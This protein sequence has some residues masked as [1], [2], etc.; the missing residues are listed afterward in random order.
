MAG[1]G[2]TA[3]GTRFEAGRV[4][5][6][7]SSLHVM[8]FG[9]PTPGGTAE[10][11]AHGDLPDGS[12]LEVWLVD[13]M[14]NRLVVS[15]CGL[16]GQ[17]VPWSRIGACG[18]SPQTRWCFPCAAARKPVVG[19]VAVASGRAGGR[20]GPP[21]GGPGGGQDGARRGRQ[22]RR[23]WWSARRASEARGGLRQKNQRS[24]SGEKKS[25]RRRSLQAVLINEWTTG[26]R[27]RLGPKLLGRYEVQVIQVAVPQSGKSAGLMVGARSAGRESTA[28][29]G[30]RTASGA[31]IALVEDKACSGRW[32]RHRG[33]NRQHKWWLQLTLKDGKSWVGSLRLRPNR[34]R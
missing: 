14:I 13:R 25:P 1:S 27:Y 8:Q 15:G 34:R 32:C 28:W 23:R 29:I 24:K 26:R 22:A 3:I 7:E 19:S 5:L 2:G 21:D 30:M 4:Q 10:L 31:K 20:Q 6:G 16:V 12:T 33:A 18:F 11:G 17:A 9:Q